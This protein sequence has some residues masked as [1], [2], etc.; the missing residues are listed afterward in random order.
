MGFFGTS[1]LSAAYLL[2]GQFGAGWL[3]F[4][5]DIVATNGSAPS[6]PHA[7]SDDAAAGS[8]VAASPAP[9]PA[10]PTGS[11]GAAPPLQGR[12][13]NDVTRL[14]RQRRRLQA[15]AADGEQ[16]VF[17][18]RDLYHRRAYIE[19]IGLYLIAE[20]GVFERIAVRLAARTVN[21]TFSPLGTEPASRV[22][23]RW[24]TPAVGK[25]PP[26]LNLDVTDHSCAGGNI[27]VVR[28]AHACAPPEGRGVWLLLT[29][30]DI[31]IQ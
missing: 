4:L 19:P 16:V 1:L 22:R 13:R 17:V 18:P 29:W 20:S 6:V 23:L 28:A 30:Q 5:C 3:C 10:G 25:R 9:G 11:S 2:H 31:S 7:A 8:A 21:V 15:A 12:G 27:T 24:E 14:L 26:L